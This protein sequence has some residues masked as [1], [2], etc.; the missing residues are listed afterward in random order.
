MN[1]YLVIGALISLVGVLFHGAA[2]Q[3]NTWAKF[4][5]VKWRN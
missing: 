5:K 1:W 2:G 3:K 4:I